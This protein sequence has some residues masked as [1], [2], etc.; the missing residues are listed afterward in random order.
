MVCIREGDPTRVVADLI[1]RDGQPVP[2]PVVRDRHRGLLTGGAAPQ[3]RGSRRVRCDERSWLVVCF[4]HPVRCSGKETVPEQPREVTPR[5]SRLVGD[6][7]HVAAGSATEVHEH[8]QCRTVATE[9]DRTTD[10]AERDTRATL[11]APAA[12]N[13][14]IDVPTR[15]IADTQGLKA[16]GADCLHA[17]GNPRSAAVEG[18][19]ET[20]DGGRVGTPDGVDRPAEEG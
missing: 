17:A 14:A 1:E 9:V 3:F 16:D 11:P 8:P 18:P 19:N 2:S 7:V 6:V 10:V 12:V 4:G 20:P 13:G 5:V 15:D